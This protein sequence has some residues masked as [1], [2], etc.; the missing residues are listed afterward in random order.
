MSSL[1]WSGLAPAGRSMLCL[2][3]GPYVLRSG[4]RFDIPEG[5]KRLLAFVA[6][7]TPQTAAAG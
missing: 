6:K 7:H 2:V 4:E 1:A 5:S 3:G